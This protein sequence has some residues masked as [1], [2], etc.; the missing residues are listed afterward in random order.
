MTS[1]DATQRTFQCE[2]FRALASGI[3]ETAGTTF[4]LLI[5][6]RW[7]QAGSTTKALIACGGSLGLLLSP[8]VVFLV[9]K[10]RC[11]TAAAASLVAAFGAGCFL[12]MALFQNIVVFTG[13]SVLA[14][15]A[16]SAIIPLLT[17]IYQE[18]YPAETRG[19]LFSQTLMIR[20][21]A[22]IFFSE[23]AGRA[24][25]HDL[26][27]FT[28][29]LLSFATA[30]ALASFC[31]ARCPSKVLVSSGASHPFRG[32]RFVA[33]DRVFRQTLLCWM[34]MGFANLM[35]L[36]MRIEYLA[37]PR[38]NLALTVSQIALLTG[39]I[40]NC[41][42]LLLSPVW[43]WL[44][45]HANFFALRMTLNI[46]FALGILAFFTS[47]DLWGLF[48]GA[49]IHGISNAG[50]DVAW[51]LWVTKFAPENRVAD[52]MAVHT[53]FTG[54]RGVLAPIV[55]FHAITSMSF[56]TLGILSAL[57]IA[58]ATAILLPELKHG[59]KAQPATAL[60]EEISD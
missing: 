2:R 49:V 11:R 35:M 52:Y 14:M 36:P 59:R 57:L 12:V 56:S 60:V 53:F 22:T 8:V 41:A 16:S 38:Y 3:I 44:F 45:D 46:G 5:A 58:A 55:G 23:F 20:I 15:A 51:S 6:V 24:L 4:L 32:L 34:L 21:G 30:F 40:P 37:N 1:A 18:N 43:G 48:L 13:G 39:V 31:L 9:E 17:Q 25:T 47:T 28:W 33:S 42:R 27:H 50:G 7:F 26:S 10:L 19:R 54:I 29:L